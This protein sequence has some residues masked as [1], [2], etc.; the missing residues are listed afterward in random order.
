MFIREKAY[1]AQSTAM[2]ISLTSRFSAG[3]SVNISSIV[4]KKQKENGFF[5]RRIKWVSETTQIERGE[6]RRGGGTE[7]E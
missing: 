5:M 3:C 6:E 1:R 7:R 2:T 4:D